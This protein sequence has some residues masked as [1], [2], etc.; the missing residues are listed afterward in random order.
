MSEVTTAEQP[1]PGGSLAAALARVAADP[2]IDPAR[3]RELHA[4]HREIVADEARAAFHE[5][6]RAMQR[7]MPRVKKNGTVSLVKDGVDKGSYRFATWED[8]DTIVRPIL[9]RYGFSVTFSEVASDANGIRW[10]ATWRRAGHAEQNFITLP[11]DAGHGRN[12]LQARGS[13]SSYA[14]RYLTEDFCNIVREAADD[15]GV[16]GGRKYLDAERVAEL[17]GLAHA[18]GR[19]EVQLLDGMFGGAIRSFAEISSEEGYAAVRNTLAR[20]QRQKKGSA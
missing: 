18:V 12:P 14:K 15:D 16:R 8:I 19:D 7:E 13:T 9:D 17:E 10:A 5:A 3:M 20:L 4:I 6:L 11:A 1:R 2:N